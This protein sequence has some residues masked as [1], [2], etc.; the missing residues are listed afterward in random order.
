M[1]TQAL[2]GSIGAY[3]SGLIHDH[4]G[5]YQLALTGF[6]GVYLAAIVT[7]FLAGKPEPYA[8]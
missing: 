6:V 4:F 5:S 7:I 2:G 3:T 8:T 1:L